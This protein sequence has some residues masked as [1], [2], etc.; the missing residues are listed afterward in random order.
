MAGPPKLAYDRD[1][2]GRGR[3]TERLWHEATSL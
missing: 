2:S 3:M 1:R